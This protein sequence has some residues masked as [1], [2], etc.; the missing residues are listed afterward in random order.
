MKNAE[1]SQRAYAT[2]ISVLMSVYNTKEE[3]L[4][5]AIESI[6]CQSFSDYEFI[7]FNDCS[8]EKTTAVLREYQDE[9]IKL[10][11]NPENRGLTKNLN[12]GIALAR[13]KYIARMDADDISLPNRLKIQYS[14]MEK[15]PDVDIL[16][17]EVLF[18]DFKSV[19]W[20]YF[21]QEWRRVN[22]LF[23][24]HGIC[25]PTAFFRA[26]FLRKNGMFYNEEY[27]KSQDYELWT[28]AFRVGRLAVCKEPVLY[29]RCH[30]G[31]ISVSSST[32]ARQKELDAQIRKNLFIELIPNAMSNEYEQLLNM[33]MEILSVDDLSKLL[34]CFVMENE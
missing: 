8:D 5:K 12:T 29:Y 14:Y 18:D 22:Q 1:L 31:Q 33:D 7:I 16:G 6:L 25:H 10:I 13:G 23:T 28:R 4:R 24:N 19:C 11:E 15:Y 26:E 21:P 9:R 3:Y 32:S 2:S 30:D 34:V 17:G 20:R 27:D